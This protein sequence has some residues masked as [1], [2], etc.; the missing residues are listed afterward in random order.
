MIL[1]MEETGL[2]EMVTALHNIPEARPS[3]THLSFFFP[4]LMYKICGSRVGNSSSCGC[5]IWVVSLCTVDIMFVEYGLT[6][7]KSWKPP[8]HMLKERRSPP[9]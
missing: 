8:V 3:P 4:P 6:L 5:L 1:L 9:Q 2:H 7:S